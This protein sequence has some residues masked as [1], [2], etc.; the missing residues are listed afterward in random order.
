MSCDTPKKSFIRDEDG[1]F[2]GGQSGAV[3]P[4]AAFGYG[5]TGY[6]ISDEIIPESMLVTKEGDEI[7]MSDVR[8]HIGKFY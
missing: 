5:I 2:L 8:T 4:D 7:A 1:T 3:V 6:G